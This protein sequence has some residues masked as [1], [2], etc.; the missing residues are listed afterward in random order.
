MAGFAVDIGDEGSEFAQGVNMPSYASGAAAAEGIS[1]LGK[2][3][4]GLLDDIDSAKAARRPTEASQKRDA[5]AQFSRTLDTGKGMNDMQKRALASR[6]LSSLNNAG[7]PTDEG[8]ASAIKSKLGIDVDYL[9]FDPNQA[10]IDKT[11]EK[12][13]DNPAYLYN[14]RNKL[15][16]TGQPFNDNDVLAEAMSMVQKSEAS[17]LFLANSKNINRAD[18]FD[19]YLPQANTKIKEIRD[20]AIAGLEIEKS[21]GTITPENLTE[22]RAGFGIV[23][24]TLVKPPQIEDADWE[25]IKNQLDT[26][27]S[28]IDT[29]ATY[30]EET[31][32]K[33]TADYLNVNSEI[34]LK[35][36]RSGELDPILSRAILS[37]KF[38]PTTYIAEHYNEVL[39]ALNKLESKD[40]VYTDLETGEVFTKAIQSGTGQT[41]DQQ[42]ASDGTIPPAPDGT[43][44]TAPAPEVGAQPPVQPTTPDLHDIDEVSK[45]EER[46]MIGKRLAI[47]VAVANRISP[48]QPEL[49]NSPEHRD[50]FF[51]GIGQATVNMSTS[52]QIFERG[53]MDKVFNDDTYKRLSMVTKLDPEKGE[54]ARLRLVDAIK[55]QATNASTAAAGITRDSYFKI[56]GLG[57]V[58]YDLERRVDTGQI[59]MD[60]AVLPLVKTAASKYY[61]GDVTAM[62]ADR[63]RRV[64]TFER[65][66]IE[67]SGFKFGV[68]YKQ[69]REV[70]KTAQTMEYYVKHMK[71]LGVDT[72]QIEQTLIKPT[73]I[74]EEGQLGTKAN[75]YPIFWSDETDTDEKLFAALNDGDHFIGPDGKVY[76]KGRQ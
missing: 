20:L 6:A 5:F 33:A 34:L 47:T 73:S 68:A 43:V 54:Q 19:S 74:P 13:G 31:L 32:K 53:T 28:L 66:Q 75:P 65:S 18:F 30:D 27:E 44:P 57:K 42:P 8:V 58:E 29:L 21:G 22:L 24:S 16:S 3:L 56:T 51:A 35:L 23:K 69:Y 36:A 17:A 7:Y 14:A 40:I 59:R 60:R 9:S 76:V 26:L 37:D 63:A 4:F 10:A 41:Q 64:P 71:K 55:S 62:V 49:L 11:L 39:E 67:N 72:A 52:G 46:P 2:N 38:D 45:A 48:A 15:K 61:K 12:I 25:P 1:M 50:N 70:Q